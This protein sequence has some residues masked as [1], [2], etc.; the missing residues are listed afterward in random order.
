MLWTPRPPTDSEWQL[1]R[2]ATATQLLEDDPQLLDNRRGRAILNHIKEGAAAREIQLAQL[3]TR[4]LRE[5]QL[6]AASGLSIEASELAGGE[7]WTNTLEAVAEF[8]LPRVFPHFEEIAP[9]LRILTPS[10]ADTLCLE[11]LRRPATEPY[12]AASH[13][14]LVRA[15]AEPLGIAKAD[16]GRWKIVS[17]RADLTQEF[18]ALAQSASTLSALDAHFSKSDWGLKPEQLAIAVCA[19]LRSGELAA[20]DARGQVLP[21][22]QIGMPLRRAVHAVRPGRLLGE[23]E[24]TRLQSVAKILTDEKLGA[25]SFEEQEHARVLLLRWQGE[26]KA[27]I[28]LASARLNQ[29]RRALNSASAP[30]PQSESTLAGVARLN[31]EL[32]ASDGDE[33]LQ[34]AA[35][36]HTGKIE[37]LMP[38]WRE[39]TAQLESRQAI[40]ISTSALLLNPELSPPPN[41][42]AERNELLL[43]FQ[44]GEEVLADDALLQQVAQWRQ[45]YT[46]EYKEWHQAQNNSARWNSLRRILNCDELRAL[47]RLEKIRTRDFSQP[48]SIRQQIQSELEKQC[49]RDGVLLPGEAACNACRLKLGARVLLRD[50]G[51]IESFIAQQ[52]QAF[53]QVLEEQRPREYLSRDE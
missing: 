11:I 46:R 5:G 53:A 23:A 22:P 18:L 36:L 13:E 1:A 26:T 28:E 12:F 17:P 44:S 9:R 48:Q 10:N 25:R 38:R 3:A 30:W 45:E 33:L 14:R 50:A 51:E 27:Q 41:L 35:N 29:L 34:R 52:L 8:A 43:R 32:S 31:E 47:E 42:Q 4:L 37:L 6:V 16:K 39:L 19:L 2:E 15:L 20:L 21:A 49:P 24:W 7:S 40:L